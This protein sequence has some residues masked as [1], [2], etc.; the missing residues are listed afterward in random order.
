MS[1]ST[2]VLNTTTGL[3]AA[4]LAFSLFST[5]DAA[6]AIEAGTTDADG[7]YRFTT[8]LEP[9][10]YRI[11]F[12]TADYLDGTATLYPY[13]DITF[14]VSDERGGANGHLHIPLLLSPYGYST[15]QGS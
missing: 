7:R 6:S 5:S 10:T 4:G 1:L 13:V 11:R 12:A 14:T 8:L 3:P 9:G 15:Y 2:H